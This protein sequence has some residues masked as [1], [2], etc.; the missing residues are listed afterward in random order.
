[1]IKGSLAIQKGEIPPNLLFN[2]LNPSIE[3]YYR[4]LHV[5]TSLKKW[6]ALPEGVPRRVSVNS[7]GE[8]K[9]TT[10]IIELL[11]PAF[12]NLP[13]RIWW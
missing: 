3:P 8:Y 10:G 11:G 5:P 7:F 1:M 4:G 12:M 13:F 2:R 6:P 9:N